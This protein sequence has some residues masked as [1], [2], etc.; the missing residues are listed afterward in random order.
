MCAYVSRASAFESGVEADVGKD[1]AHVDTRKRESRFSFLVRSLV[2]ELSNADTAASR[3]LSAAIRGLHANG[4]TTGN[5]M[6][7]ERINM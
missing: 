7:V 3:D 6:S 1:P 5:G 2:I 4:G